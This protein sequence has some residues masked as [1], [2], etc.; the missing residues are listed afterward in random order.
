MAMRKRI[1][2]SSGIEASVVGFGAWA[3]GGWMWG[4]TDERESIDAIHAALDAGVDLIDTAAIYGF[5]LSE[6]IVGR[7]IRDRRDRVV[8]ATKCALVCNPDVGMPRFRSTAL[9]ADP[10]GHVVI[11]V[12][13]HPDSIRREVEASLRRLQTDY[14]DLYQTHAQDETTPIADTMGALLDLKQQ[15]KIRAIGVS[16]ATASQM[17][18]YCRVGPLDTDQESYSMIDRK[19][20]GDQLPFCRNHGLA[21]L[22]Y[23]PLGRGML[24]GKFG[25]DRELAEGDHRRDN[26]LY[27]VENRRRVSTLLDTIRPIAQKRGITLPQLVIAWTL[28]QPGVTHALVGARN[29]QQAE[30]NAA[31]GGVLLTDEELGMIDRAIVMLGTLA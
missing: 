17:E 22:A 13:T 16:N 20:E 1:L 5:G 26:P 2:G 28:H 19:I 24:T 18:A 27:S 25:P 9:G 15:G 7:A 23:S 6:R 14:I 8:L 31:G 10:D 4:G 30:E 21:M 29:R 11:H 12:H 3:L